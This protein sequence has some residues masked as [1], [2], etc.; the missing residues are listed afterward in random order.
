M[1]RG[2]KQEGLGGERDGD[3]GGGWVMLPA[4]EELRDG[5]KD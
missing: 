5:G 1:G 4:S 2:R 3:G